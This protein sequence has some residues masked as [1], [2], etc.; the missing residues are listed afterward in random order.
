[1]KKIL[2]ALS[3]P[4]LIVGIAFDEGMSQTPLP[5]ISVFPESQDFGRVMMGQSSPLQPF[6]IANTGGENMV[7]SSIELTGGDSRIFNLD[8]GTCGS[9]KPIIPAGAR[10]N[11]NAVFTPASG[12]GK[13]T[14]LKIVSNAFNSP[15][16]GVPLTGTGLQPLNVGL[17]LALD[18]TTYNFG[19]P[20]NLVLTLQNAG[21]DLYTS[22]GFKAKPFELFL[23]FTGPDEKIITSIIL[24]DTD[25]QDPPPPIV[26]VLPTGELVPNLEP[27][28]KVEAGWVMSINISDAHNYYLL[29][30]GG[31]YSVKSLIPMRTYPGIDHTDNRLVPPA[32][33]SLI[34]RYNSQGALESNIVNF[35]LLAPL[36]TYYIDIEPRSS[37]ILAGGSQIYKATGFDFSNNSLGDMTAATTFSITNGTCAL[38]VCTSNLSGNQ[39]VTA[40]YSG[41]TAMASLAVNPA[42]NQT[43]NF[44][45]IPNKTYGDPPFAL[46]ATAT[47]GLTVALS[48]VSGPATISGK[49]VTITGVGTVTVRASQTGNKDYF[50]APSVDRSFQV[51]FKQGDL[52]LD[53]KVDCTDIK[54]VKASFGKKYGQAGF[55][56]RADLN[57]DHVVDVRDLAAVS[58]RLPAGT[59]CP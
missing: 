15:A 34:D 25:Q 14:A 40:N 59:K 28:E 43:I 24:K 58:Q 36:D 16:V 17:A 37:T 45:A 13:A 20:I 41:K 47:S 2:L 56:P 4:I 44:T 54:I 7:V 38:N 48:I 51:S 11:I 32:D 42:A 35:T 6:T 39:T 23:I 49:V 53:G 30:K 19:E 33:Y 50:P 5:S 12:G 46:T 52:N 29:S 10:C 18:K 1:M 3:V 55:D 57:N 26:L 8:M 9:L 27:V 22:R 31:S 21:G